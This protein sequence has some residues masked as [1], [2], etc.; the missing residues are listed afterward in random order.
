MSPAYATDLVRRRYL[1]KALPLVGTMNWVSGVVGFVG[2]G[3]VLDTFGAASL[4]GTIA[5]TSFMAVIILAFLPA[6]LR[7]K[8]SVPVPEPKGSLQSTGD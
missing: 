5:L 7:P 3:Y 4:Y 6:S 8:V 2:A 1:G